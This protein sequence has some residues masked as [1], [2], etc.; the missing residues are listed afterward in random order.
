MVDQIRGSAQDRVPRM[1]R[2]MVLATLARLDAVDALAASATALK[3]AAATVA[4]PT[5]IDRSA[6]T[7][8]TLT[9]MAK[10]P[11]QVQITTAGV[12]PADAPATAKIVGWTKA[13]QVEETVTVAQTATTA[14]SVNYFIDITR[15]ELPAADGV[16]ATLAFGIT[17]N[18]GL[19][20]KV[21]GRGA[22]GAVLP[23][24]QELVN[25]AAPTAG[26][27]IAP[28]TALPNGAYT[29]HATAA[30]DG[31]RDHLVLYEADV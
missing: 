7:L 31:A 20:V 11:R 6:L 8:A 10:V 24:L 29:P 13:G 26:A 23:I 27:L 17:G 16:A 14:N 19:P 15:I 18:L 3:T 1:Q 9:D 5:T 21:K 2:E 4:A 22:A 28:A 30:A 12:T 25:G